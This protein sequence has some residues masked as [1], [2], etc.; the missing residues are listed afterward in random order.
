M[1]TRLMV[2]VL[3][4]ARRLEGLW[5]P[6]LVSGGARSHSAMEPDWQLFLYGDLCI[7]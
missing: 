6:L 3:I 5:F 2:L 1:K 4:R 7:M